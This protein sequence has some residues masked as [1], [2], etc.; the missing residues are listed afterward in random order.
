MASGPPVV[1]LDLPVHREICQNAGV[2]FSRFSPGELAD[3]VMEVVVDP[4]VASRLRARGLERSQDFSWSRHT[5]E[6]VNL[7]TQLASV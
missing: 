3:R 5:D 2:Y 6:L 1:A 4:S 7:A